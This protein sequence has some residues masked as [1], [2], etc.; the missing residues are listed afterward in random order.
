MN[1]VISKPR[2]NGYN[3]EIRAIDE[4]TKRMTADPKAARKFLIE[5]GF[6]N[7]KTGKLTKRYGG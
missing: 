7:P 5:S 3:A 4:F 2:N 1:V 6:M